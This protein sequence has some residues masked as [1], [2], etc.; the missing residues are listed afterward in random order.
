MLAL[1]LLPLLVLCHLTVVALNLPPIITNLTADWTAASH[2]FQDSEARCL[3]D[4]PTGPPL[5]LLPDCIRAISLLPQS[6]YVGT[7]H[8]GGYPSI[9]QLPVSKE[10]GS[11]SAMVLLHED[12]DQEIGS[13]DDIRGE[14]RRLLLAC[15]L[16]FEEEGEQRTGGWITS[17]VE[18]G[19]VVELGRSR[20]VGVLRGMSGADVESMRR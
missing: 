15:R 9:F 14:A 16:P 11:C 10:Y 2:G 12:R 19:L 17:G 8:I 3:Q 18:N 6:H 20:G 5:P 13:W 4:Q 7:F 1:L